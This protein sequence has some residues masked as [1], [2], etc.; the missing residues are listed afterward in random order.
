MAQGGN[1]GGPAKGVNKILGNWKDNILIGTDG[2]DVIFGRGG[3]DLLNGGEGD[4]FLVGG[5][6]ADLLDG[7]DG[8]DTASYAGSPAGVSIDL[9]AGTASGGDADGDTLISIENVVGS[10]L[11]DTLSGD[12]GANVLS[13][14]DGDDWLFGANGNDVLT[15]GAGADQYV[16][17]V[18]DPLLGEVPDGDDIITDFEIGIDKIRFTNTFFDVLAGA[19]EAGN[20]VVITYGGGSTITLLNTQLGAL[21][22]SDFVFLGPNVIVG[23]DNDDILIGTSGPDNIFGLGGSDSIVG[24]GGADLLDGGDGIDWVFYLASPAGVSVDLAAGTG[25][26]GDAA[27]DTLISIE[28]VVGSDFADTLAGDGGANFLDGRGGDDTLD[29]RDGDDLLSGG[30]GTDLLVGG[31]GDD[32]LHGGAGADQLQGGTGADTAS[33]TNSAAVIIDLALGVI[34]GGDAEGDTFSSIENLIGSGGSDILTGDAGNNVIDG[35]LGGNDTISGGAGND[36]L[37]AFFGNNTLDGGGGD[38]FLSFGTFGTNFAT[39]G[40]GADTF[41]FVDEISVGVVPGFNNDPANLT[42]ITDF[43]SGVDVIEFGEGSFDVLATAEQRGSD[44][45]IVYGPERGVLLLETTVA[46]ILASDF[47]FV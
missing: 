17:H 40:T 28:V 42:T 33:Y 27:G 29:G 19:V 5:S 23:T 26:G 6:G 43:E 2:V 31:A 22:N 39:G 30:A 14:G 36:T 13:G 32:T 34:S 12:A 21:S 44:L 46:D 10:G 8:I 45:L 9:A 35:G 25:S 15:G 11:A 1:G 20:D 24:G 16:F 41:S 47:V 3:N 7:G 4:D 37:S 38:D 18:A